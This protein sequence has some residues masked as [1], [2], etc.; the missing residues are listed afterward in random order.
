[1]SN[2][3][4]ELLRTSVIDVAKLYGN[5]NKTFLFR[6]SIGIRGRDP[7]EIRLMFGVNYYSCSTYEDAEYN[8]VNVFLVFQTNSSQ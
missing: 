1:M 3:L 8:D 2:K 7:E 4:V 6:V 5:I